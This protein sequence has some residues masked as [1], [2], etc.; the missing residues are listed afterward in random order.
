M[1]WKCAATAFFYPITS[2]G[3]TSAPGNDITGSDRGTW[4][5]D[6]AEG[7]LFLAFSGIKC[8]RSETDS[9]TDSSVHNYDKHDAKPEY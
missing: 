2:A 8:T 3:A 5:E 7:F 1:C 9:L 6:D 4:R